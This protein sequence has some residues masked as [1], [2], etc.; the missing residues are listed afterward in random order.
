MTS[1]VLERAFALAASGNYPSVTDIKKVLKSEGYDLA[2]VT[3][4]TLLKQLR[5]AIVSTRS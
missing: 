2:Q 4:S 3:G 1:T 5:G